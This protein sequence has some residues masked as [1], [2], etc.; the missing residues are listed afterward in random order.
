VPA[1]DQVTSLTGIGSS[2]RN[3]PVAFSTTNW[4]VV[5]EAQGRSPAAQEALEK[6]CRTY[7][8]PVYSFIR[9][10]GTGPE[11]AEDLTQSFFALLLERRNFDAVRKEKGR[12]RSYLLTS[13]KHFL[14]SEHRRA[15]TLKRGKGQQPVPLDEVSGA[16]RSDME[17]AD[18]LT[19]ERVYERRW[20]LTLME[21]VLRR[22]KEEY[23]TAGNAA[24][25]D[26]LKQLL[27][28][29]P[30]TQSRADIAM[31]LGM[32]DNALRQAF[33]RFRHRYQFWLREEI[34]HTVAVASDVE[35][36]LRHLIAVLRA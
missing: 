10:E 24:L 27:P 14:V 2:E 13:L 29:E 11:E 36:E 28:D 1:D 3:G 6:L 9:R 4:S 20:A 5:L 18:H 32:T 7:W 31:Q 19:A 26:S 12:L 30:G 25:F 23:C 17:P 8:R 15:V 35:D 33:H 21:Q 34:S 22:L 16:E